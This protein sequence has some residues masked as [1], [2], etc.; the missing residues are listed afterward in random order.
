MTLAELLLTKAGGTALALLL[1]LG[2]VLFLRRLYGP[3]GIWRDPRWDAPAED[4]G[5]A[6]FLAY[7]HGFFTG[8]PGKDSLLALKVEHTLRVLEE[9]RAIAAFEPAFSAALP[10]RALLLAALYH[11]LGRFE[12]LRRYRTFADACSCNHGLLGA[13]ILRRVNF[14]AGEPD[15]VRR[16]VMAAVALHNRRTLPEGLSGLNRL[17]TLGVRDADKTDI[18][19]IMAG[20]LAAGAIADPAVLMHL[21]DD[22]ESWSASLLSALEEGRTG[23]FQD[24]RSYNDFRLLLCTWLYDLTFAVSVR[25]LREAG[26]LEAVLGGLAA[27]PEVQAR[28]RRAVEAFFRAAADA[29]RQ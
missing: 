19:R 8:E 27:V 15:E 18:L 2:L 13:G 20:Q 12:Q 4:I 28:A 24:M 16:P 25:R 11:D 3:K 22:P 21:A 5:T 23:S 9:A 29:D 26:H 7:A 17:V 14:L 6:P 10:R 1:L